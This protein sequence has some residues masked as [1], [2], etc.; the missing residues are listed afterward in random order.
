MNESIPPT[1]E[2]PLSKAPNPE[3]LHS[4]A[5]KM[6]T[7]CSGCVFMVCLCVCVCGG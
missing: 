5:A 7:H 6:V 3:M 2:V 1:T 4:T